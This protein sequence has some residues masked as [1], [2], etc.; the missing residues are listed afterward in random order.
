[1][2]IAAIW[3]AVSTLLWMFSVPIKSNWDFW[4]VPFL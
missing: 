1:M 3:G 2:T 4:W